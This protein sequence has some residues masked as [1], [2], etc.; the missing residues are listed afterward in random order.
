MV[1]PNVRAWTDEEVAEWYANWPSGCP[2]IVT[3]PECKSEAAENQ[4]KVGADD[5][6]TERR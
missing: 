3:A 6:D 2:E 5:A 4:K 1:R